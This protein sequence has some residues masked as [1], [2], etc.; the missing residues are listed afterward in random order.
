MS[1]SVAIPSSVAKSLSISPT[2]DWGTLLDPRNDRISKQ[3]QV[4][5]SLPVRM[6]DLSSDI[7]TA[8]TQPV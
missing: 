7:A 2:V 5:S 1:S 4:L 8:F 6:Q 3:L